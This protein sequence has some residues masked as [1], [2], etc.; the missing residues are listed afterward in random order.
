MF[1]TQG[2]SIAVGCFL[3]VLMDRRKSVLFKV[4][5]FHPNICRLLAFGATYSNIF[6]AA[7]L[8]RLGISFPTRLFVS[9]TPTLQCISI[10]YLIGSLVSVR[11]G[12]GYW[13]MNCAPVRWVGRLS[14]SLYIWQQIVL[15][16]AALSIFPDSWKAVMWT[17]QFPQNLV[18]VFL[19]AILSYY[20]LEKPILKLKARFA[21][22]ESVA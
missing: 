8:T 1:F 2:D 19:F 15:I 16:P 10:C 3:A 9:F 7:L 20:C 11:S 4:F 22:V 13:L 14:Y 21:S 12:I 5:Q 17:L 18:F 6:L